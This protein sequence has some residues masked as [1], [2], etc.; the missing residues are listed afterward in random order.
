LKER[1]DFVLKW[2]PDD[3]QFIGMRP[4]GMPTPGSDS[5]DAPPNLFTTIQEQLGLKLESAKAP[6]DV[7]IIEHVEK[8]A[9]N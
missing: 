3:S 2:M 1:Y 9:A 8:P 7:M 6:V 4:P 5:P